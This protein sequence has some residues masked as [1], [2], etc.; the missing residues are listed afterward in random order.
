MFKG[1]R[2]SEV[3]AVPQYLGTSLHLYDRDRV[4]VARTK[5][6]GKKD[7]SQVWLHVSGHVQC[8][9]S[10]QIKRMGNSQRQGKYIDLKTWRKETLA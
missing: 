2:A 9:K 5:S 1:L 6:G 3:V 4:C 7:V 10:R 8:V